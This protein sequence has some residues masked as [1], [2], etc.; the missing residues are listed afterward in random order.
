MGTDRVEITQ[1][2]CVQVFVGMCLIADDLLVDLL[3][4]AVGRERFLYRS[5]LIDRQMVCVRLVTLCNFI[6]SSKVIRLPMLLR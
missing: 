4:V 2:G 5:I 6:T 3:G 1:D